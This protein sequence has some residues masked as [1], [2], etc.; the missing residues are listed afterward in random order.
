MGFLLILPLTE[1]VSSPEAKQPF[2]YSLAAFNM[3]KLVNATVGP[4]LRQYDTSISITD[5]TK[6]KSIP[7]FEHGPQSGQYQVSRDMTMQVADRTWKITFKSP[8]SNLVMAAERFAPKI[9]LGVGAGLTVA[10]CAILY[11][12]RLRSRLLILVAAEE[13]RT[14]RETGL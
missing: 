7:L 12:L 10:I 3:D 2:G 5:V 4:R 14:K 6:G 9:I 13:E 1:R 8:S 11:M